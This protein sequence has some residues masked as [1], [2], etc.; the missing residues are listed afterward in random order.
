MDSKVRKVKDEFSASLIKGKNITIK[1][2]SDQRPISA[3]V[4]KIDMSKVSPISPIK[5]SKINTKDKE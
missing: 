4:K 5:F 2:K 1:V 3:I